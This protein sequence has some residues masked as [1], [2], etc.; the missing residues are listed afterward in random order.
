MVAAAKQ[1][2]GPTRVSALLTVEQVKDS[3]V[4]PFDVAAGKVRTF[5]IDYDDIIA[6]PGDVLWVGVD[7]RIYA[8]FSDEFKADLYRK[9][10]VG[11]ARCSIDGHMNA[12]CLGRTR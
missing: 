4:L 5:K 1:M 7:G 11:C 9:N 10:F 2:S 3:K 6:I 12:F 8:V